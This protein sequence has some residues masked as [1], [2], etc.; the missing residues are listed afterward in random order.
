MFYLFQDTL[1]YKNKHRLL[2]VKMLD[3]AVKTVMVSI[4]I[5]VNV[6]RQK[7]DILGQKR[8]KVG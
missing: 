5:F 8:D 2:K 7:R 4:N 6:S 1:E 3:G